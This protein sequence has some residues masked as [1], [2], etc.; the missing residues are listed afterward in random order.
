M[1]AVDNLVIVKRNLIE[2]RRR[3]ATTGGSA[4]CQ[5][6]AFGSSTQFCFVYFTIFTCILYPLFYFVYWNSVFIHHLA[7]I[8]FSVGIIRYR[9]HCSWTW[10]N[11]VIGISNLNS[12][13]LL[14][15]KFSFSYCTLLLVC[16]RKSC[17]I[18]VLTQHKRRLH[19]SQRFDITNK[20][21]KYKY[22]YMCVLLLFL[23]FMWQ[24]PTNCLLIDWQLVCV[25]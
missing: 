12:T 3:Q 16:H 13:Y 17:R 15:Y 14:L 10:K 25:I 5:C 19:S 7:F 24:I 6:A 11:Q 2:Q 20:L 21:S 22:V 9:F 8:G 23:H 4:N 1:S 18:T